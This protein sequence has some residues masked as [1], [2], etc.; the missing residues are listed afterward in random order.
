MAGRLT[1]AISAL[2]AVLWLAT[3]AQADG[4][5]LYRWVDD[6]GQ[7]HYGDKVPPNDAKRGRESINKSGLV[8]KVMPREMSGSELEQAQA[9][10]AAQKVADEARAQRLVYD[11]YLLQAFGSVADLQLVREERLTAL[12]ARI[13]QAESAVAANEKTLVD[14]R[15]RAAGKPA[16]GELKQQTEDYE[17]A[18]IESLQVA[19]KLRDERAA[20]EI[21]Y[22]AEIERFK[23]LR[24][25]TIKQG[26]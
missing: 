12:N 9:R 21:K 18:L 3:A 6:K 16:A 22:A 25:G 8:T 7:V 10:A 11:R 14:L 13:T 1:K 26:E 20:T 24:A 2:A 23:A 4:K 15:A 19:R 5:V 17:T